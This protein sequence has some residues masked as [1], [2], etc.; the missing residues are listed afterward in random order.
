[1]FERAADAHPTRADL[2]ELRRT[3]FFV[4]E[5]PRKAEVRKPLKRLKKLPPP[6]PPP[7]PKEA[8]TIVKS[9][10]APRKKWADAKVR[11]Q[12]PIAWQ[13]HGNTLAIGHILLA[14]A[15]AGFFWQAETWAFPIDCNV[16]IRAHVP[17][18]LDL[19]MKF[20]KYAQKCILF[21]SPS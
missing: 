10:W 19:E 16:E 17:S 9:I 20:K 3:R 21:P 15:F 14:I 2:N 11:H 8:W 1:M 5:V 6:P 12:M 4:S 18:I 7:K 13:S